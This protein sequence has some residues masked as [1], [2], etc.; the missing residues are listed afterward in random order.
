LIFKNYDA[1]NAVLTELNN[2]TYDAD[3]VE[4]VDNLNCAL[5]QENK[6][7]WAS[8]P[9]SEGKMWRIEK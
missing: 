5:L 9:L 4:G 8:V 7:Y 1:I 6:I 3:R 2:K